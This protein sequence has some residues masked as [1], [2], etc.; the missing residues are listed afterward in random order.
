MSDSWRQEISEMKAQ[1]LDLSSR[2]C[3]LEE[4]SRRFMV[5]VAKLMGDMADIKAA[6]GSMATK[7]D[8]AA[9]MDAF[10]GLREDMRRRWAVHSDTLARHDERIG[11]LER[12]RS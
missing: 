6:M 3:T 12:R 10:A 5:A 11:K 1:V 2:V 7:S 4:A 8:I 9:Q